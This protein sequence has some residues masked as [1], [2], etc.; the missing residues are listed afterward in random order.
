MKIL[1]LEKDNILPKPV[2]LSLFFKDMWLI[3]MWVGGQK[4]GSNKKE[5]GGIYKHLYLSG[6][7]NKRK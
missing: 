4:W 6:K 5:L 7:D 1:H 3:K 2:C